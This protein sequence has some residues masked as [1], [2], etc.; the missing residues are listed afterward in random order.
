VRLYNDSKNTKKEETSMKKLWAPWRMTYISGI[1]GK[2]RKACVFCAKPKEN[3]DRKNLILF[4]GKKCFVVLNLFPYNNGHLM[5]VPYKHAADPDALDKN[6]SGELWDLVCLSRKALTRAFRP[7]GF[8]IGLNL[9]RTAGAGIDT[10]LHVHIV[11]RWNGDTN[12]MPVLGEAKV[13]SQALSEAY[14]ALAPAFRS[15]AGTSSAGPSSRKRHSR[16]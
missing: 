16:T 15:R 6:T 9:G 11:P 14:D 3:N 5:V 8:N 12:F 2:G 10:H 4:R 1:G 13:I 7:D